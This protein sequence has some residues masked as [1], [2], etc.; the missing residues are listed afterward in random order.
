MKTMLLVV[1]MM[2]CASLMAMENSSQEAAI[3]SREAIEQDIA[4][5]IEQAPQAQQLQ[6]Q[7]VILSTDVFNW[8]SFACTIG[9]FDTQ[10]AYIGKIIFDFDLATKT[11]RYSLV[12]IVPAHRQAGYAKSLIALS[13]SIMKHFGIER[14]RWLADPQDEQTSLL[15]LEKLYT[16]FGGT[17]KDRVNNK[18]V[19]EGSIGSLRSKL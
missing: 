13:I 16:S 15:G 17:I 2:A 4:T 11:G 12:D 19:M 5:L 9:L 7:G 10:M 6:K 1:G 3:I 18:T 8:G 14:A